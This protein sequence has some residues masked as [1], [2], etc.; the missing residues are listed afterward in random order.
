[1]SGNG[2]G[3]VQVRSC[4][5]SAFTKG[6]TAEERCVVRS[7]RLP[8]AHRAI[9]EHMPPSSTLAGQSLQGHQAH[10]SVAAQ[11]EEV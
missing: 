9:L 10:N 6:G 1:M 5:H 4:N 2:S 3:S 11:T 7:R 8:N